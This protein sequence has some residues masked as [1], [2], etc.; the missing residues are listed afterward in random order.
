M[1]LNEEINPRLKEAFEHR[2]GRA[3]LSVSDERIS[4]LLQALESDGASVLLTGEPGCGK[5]HLAREAAY[6]LESAAQHP[7][8]HILVEQFDE[9][10][11][12]YATDQQVSAKEAS[13]L[14]LDSLQ[15]QF[16]GR[17][18]LI[19]ALGIDRYHG[20]QASA[21]ELLVRARRVRFIG[22]ANQVTGA[23]DRIARD[24]AVRLLTV[25]PLTIEQSEAF[26]SRLLDVDR[27]SPRSLERWYAATLGNPHA[28]ATVA[29]AAERRGVV[30]RAR[31][32]AWV[33]EM[34]DHAPVDFVAQLETFQPLEPLERAA[35]ELIAFAA[36]LHE[37]T[38]LQLLDADAV[39]TLMN[40]QILTVRTDPMGLTSITTRLP[41]L[42]AAVRE[43]LSPIERTRLATLCFNALLSDDDTLT[44]ASR[45]RLV[46]F[47]IEAGRELPT[48]W[49]WQAMRT[50]GRSGNLHY[51]LRLALAAMPH[52]DALR[53]AEAIL[54]AC[55]IAHFLGL[56][57]ELDQALF[58]LTELLENFE[59]LDSVPF[60]MQFSL[61]V[62]SI[63]FAPKYDGEPELA[64]QA[65]D[66]WE[67]H[68]QSRAIDVGQVAQACRMRVLSFSGRLRDAFAAVDRN[69]EARDLESEWFAA[70]AHTFEAL[71]LVQKGRFQ[72]ALQIAETT[73]N[74]V[75]LYEISPTISGD[76]EGFTI[77]LAHWARGTTISA[78]RALDQISD[79]TRADLSAVHERSGLVDLAI[80]LFSLQEARWYDAA[81]LAERLIGTLRVN[82][83]FKITQIVQAA[84]ALALAAVGEQTRARAALVESGHQR[85]GLS[86]TLHGLAANLTLQARHWLRDADRLDHAQR[87]ADWARSEEL[88]LIELKALDVIAHESKQIDK[89][90]LARAE[91]LAELVDP[92]V[93]GAIL[94]HIRAMSLGAQSGGDAE[95]RLLSEL[96]IWL[97]LPLASGLT[98][99]EREV[100]LFIALGYTSKQVAE[101]LHLSARTVETHLTHVYTKL[102]IE[103]REALRHW[104]THGREIA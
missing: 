31:R 67:R 63:C 65:F 27:L 3:F 69:A 74:L 68:W 93:G 91:E 41:I 101:R 78:R 62:A 49:M 21:L 33:S 5:S 13:D 2:P 84:L 29:L 6:A 11:D 81:E 76:L 102:G 18:L 44:T 8:Q 83:P 75:L 25:E 39:S 15:G 20:H 85:P 17:Q 48:E 94:A 40:R 12:R 100:A 66:T 57:E 7:L 55:D 36:P 82:D 58:A 99:R 42:A 59:R 96:G 38:L 50:A 53:S 10:L 71:L 52:E 45:Q 43:H 70:P 60:V 61:A 9:L 30:Q 16:P 92:P 104:F 88:P 19:V 87:L 90:L 4:G 86:A 1:D 23:A 47:G 26:L 51:A 72:Q 35:L 98:G 97:P 77:F 22:T 37:T 79:S 64:L 32:V 54:K 103:G 73:R 28:L 24:P 89:G 14:L 95:E 56:R 34:D 46:R 80:I